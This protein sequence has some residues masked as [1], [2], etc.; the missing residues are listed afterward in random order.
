MSY[1]EEKPSVKISLPV[2]EH[3]MRLVLVENARW[4]KIISGD[5]GRYARNW[6]NFRFHLIDFWLVCEGRAA[7]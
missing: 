4:M 6:V 7:N 1:Q 3:M 2:R 5:G